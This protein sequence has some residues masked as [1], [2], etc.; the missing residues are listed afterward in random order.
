MGAR[1][2]VTGY[3]FDMAAGPRRGVASGMMLI[4]PKGGRFCRHR[5]RLPE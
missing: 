2:F 4:V 3:S 5:N 1:R